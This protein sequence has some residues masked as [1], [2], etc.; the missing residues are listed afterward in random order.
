MTQFLCS[1]GQTVSAAD[2]N[3]GKEMPCPAC[4]RGLF[5]P[6][7]A[8]QPTPTSP[9]LPG[10]VTPTANP[11]SVPHGVRQVPLTTSGLA[12][13]SMILGAASLG[14]GCVAGP[15]V[16]VVAGVPAVLIGGL[17]L[18]LVSFSKGRKKGVGLAVG[19]LLLGLI[20][21][22]AWPIASYLIV[23][24]AATLRSVNN[25]SEI[26]LAMRSYA[27]ANGTF[28]PAAIC[29]PDGKPLLSW[30]VALLPYIEQG[31]LY[32]QFKLDEA[33]DG[34]NNSK[35]LPRMPKYYAMPGDT[36]APPGCTYYR[37]FVGNG[38][39]FDPPKPITGHAW[40]DMISRK[41]WPAGGTSLADFTD[42]ASDTI[43]I[44]EAGTAAPWTKPE[45]LDYDPNGPLPPLGGRFR[46]GFHA[47]MAGGL[48]FVHWISGN[49]SEATL[50]ATIT[51]NGGDRLGPDW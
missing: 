2:E 15:F 36:K 9:G 24:R 13:A 28:P 35:L 14:V 18:A 43:L 37:V 38:A 10:D 45:E 32:K 19:G 33:W 23:E 29:G 49:T 22:V 31:E 5:I 11:L 51:R 50:R 16:S 34:P 41:G 44:V 48:P 12:V 6:R 3:A 7:A 27:D 30:R 26:D 1:C 21:G 20:G 25:L 46:G 8:V 40:T 4:G 17:A 39:A 47:A 42:G